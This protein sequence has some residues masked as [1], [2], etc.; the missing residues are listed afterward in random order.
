MNTYTPKYR[1]PCQHSLPRDAGGWELVERPS[2]VDNF[3][4]RTD[5]PKSIHAYGVISFARTLTPDELREFELRAV[6][7]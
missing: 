6:T 3:E 1:P 7:I 4:R 5:L 2:A